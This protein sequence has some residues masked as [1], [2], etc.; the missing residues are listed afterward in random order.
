MNCPYDLLPYGGVVCSFCYNIIGYVST[1]LTFED[2]KERIKELDELH[3]CE[4]KVEHYLA[5][6]EIED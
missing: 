1:S 6:A 2:R 3:S 5:N 4:G